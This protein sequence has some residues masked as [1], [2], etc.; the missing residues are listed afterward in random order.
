MEAHEIESGLVWHDA[1]LVDRLTIRPDDRLRQ[2][3]PRQPR[4]EPGAPDHVC[5]IER[6][7]IGE[8]R[9]AVTNARHTRNALDAGRIEIRRLH[10]NERTT[11]RDDGWTDLASHRRVHGENPVKDQAEEDREQPPRDTTLDAKRYIS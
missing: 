8:Q 3:D 11:L 10:A 9:R 4:M 5:D 1:P 2:I 6:A 7:P